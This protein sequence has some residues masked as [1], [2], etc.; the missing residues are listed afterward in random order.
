MF[1]Y[2]CRHTL[3]CGHSGNVNLCFNHIFN[4]YFVHGC[5]LLTVMSCHALMLC[6]VML[7]Y[8]VLCCVC[9]VILRLLLTLIKVT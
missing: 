3:L 8:V 9:D 2:V 7:C 5:S 6:Y 4:G 1:S